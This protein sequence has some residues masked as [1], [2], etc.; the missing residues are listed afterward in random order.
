[1]LCANFT[2][3]HAIIHFST[4]IS[5]H[6]TRADLI[7]SAPL[8]SQH[9]HTTF[10][11]THTRTPS[12]SH[13]HHHLFHTPSSLYHN[14]S[15]SFHRENNSRLDFLP[16]RSILSFLRVPLSFASRQLSLVHLDHS[17]LP[18]RS[19][20]ALNHTFTTTTQHCHCTHPT[21]ASRRI[22]TPMR[23]DP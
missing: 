3:A 16:L 17:S 6:G 7:V 13:H 22:C 12:C 11:L 14:R 8:S 15:R 21:A 1:M 10:I 4:T 9:H 5:G 2:T 19:G 20:P 23:F 18:A